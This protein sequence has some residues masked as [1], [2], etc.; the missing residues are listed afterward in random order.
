MKIIR[1]NSKIFLRI[2]VIGFL[3]STGTFIHYVSLGEGHSIYSVKYILWYL[4]LLIVTSFIPDNKWTRPF[5]FLIN[6]PW[7]I[8]VASG[9]I[10]RSLG[11]LYI[12]LLLFFGFTMAS[13]LI[14]LPYIFGWVIDEN[15]ALFLSMTF[16]AIVFSSKGDHILRHWI[17][18]E[19]YRDEEQITELALA[20]FGQRKIRFL[21][22]G[23]YLITLLLFTFCSLNN[24]PILSTESSIAVM[25]S[26]AAFIAFDQA[27]ENWQKIKTRGNEKS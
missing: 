17:K 26:F 18:I 13:L 9:P 25:Q 23:M 3:L 22:F 27:A 12:V 5:H 8:F 11:S 6:L 10:I 2:F 24:T 1:I 21:I 15:A 19:N 4:S 14:V 16:T 20:L 7:A